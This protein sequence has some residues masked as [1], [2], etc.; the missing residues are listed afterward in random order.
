MGESKDEKKQAVEMDASKDE[1]KQEVKMKASRDEEKQAAEMKASEDEEK[2]AAEMG[3]NKDE[4]KE[5]SIKPIEEEDERVYR[6]L[7]NSEEQYALWFA[8]HEIPKGW[9]GVGP[10]GKKEVCLSYIKEVWTDMR[11]KSLRQMA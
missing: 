1:E 7:V 2:Q 11:P 8:D 5:Q 6:V 10:T 9:E 4:E 3:E